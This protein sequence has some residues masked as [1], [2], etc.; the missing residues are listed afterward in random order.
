MFN[1]N[2]TAGDLTDSSRLLIK[3]EKLFVLYKGDVFLQGDLS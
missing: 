3:M 2:I 1:L